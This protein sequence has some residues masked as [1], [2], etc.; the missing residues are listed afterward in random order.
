MLDSNMTCSPSRS[1][2]LGLAV[3][4]IVSLSAC[5]S[6]EAMAPGQDYS[7]KLGSSVSKYPIHGIDV[8]KYQGAI[9]WHA[10]AKSGVR[11]AYIKATEGGDRKDD[12]FEEN[13]EGA[14]A[15]GIPTGAYHFYYF[16]RPVEDQIAWFQTHVPPARDALPPVLDME[17]NH[18]SPTCKL[19]PPAD[20]VRADMS[21]F[22][23]AMER[24]Y[25]KR[26]II[27]T[28]IDF[29][30][31]VLHG[32]ALGYHTFWLRS[33]ASHPDE[34]YGGRRWT[35]WQYTATG[36]VP[37]VRGKVD[38]NVFAGDETDWRRFL[39]QGTAVA[40]ATAAPSGAD[41]APSLAAAA[42][43]P[44]SAPEASP[45]VAAYAPV[46]SA[47]PDVAQVDGGAMPAAL[48]DIY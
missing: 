47:A 19:R 7:P 23:A 22:L 33:V 1:V 8:S 11:F 20:Q 21:R 27:Y 2:R 35:F 6:M 3:L 39:T 38:R 10:A 31:D 45:A 28:T 41:A 16:C 44:A 37:G 26:P 17:W 29:H 36:S 25:G 12:R 15:A 42:P 14:R 40:E 46:P 24:F 30:R 32:D 43:V 4:A 13:W 5:S 9:D 34:K 48:T 18:L